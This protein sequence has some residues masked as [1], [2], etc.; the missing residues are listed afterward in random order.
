MQ[1]VKS[2]CCSINL[3]EESNESLKITVLEREEMLFFHGG[4]FLLYLCIFF[5]SVGGSGCCIDSLIFHHLGNERR[6]EGK[7]LTLEV[8]PLILLEKQS[9]LKDSVLVQVFLCTEVHVLLDCE[10]YT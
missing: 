8:L 6:G 2:L 7:T 10:L 5:L 4:S 1:I 3:V 9:S